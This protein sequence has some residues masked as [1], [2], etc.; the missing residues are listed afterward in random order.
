[1][2]NFDKDLGGSPAHQ[3][4]KSDNRGTPRVEPR[5]G[6]DRDDFLATLL[7]SISGRLFK[8]RRRGSGSE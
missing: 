4:E 8:Y 7:A 5:R 2:G 1:M 3:R 6:W